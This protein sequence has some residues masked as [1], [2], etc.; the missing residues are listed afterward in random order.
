MRSTPTERTVVC[1]VR[2]PL[3][4]EPIDSQVETLQACEAEGMIDTAILRSWPDEV[5]LGDPAP[6]HETIEVF[7]RFDRWANH[8]GVSIRP[9]F[10]VR[11]MTS[12]VT[13]DTKEVLVTPVICLAVYRDEQLIGVY[14]HSTDDE[15]Y[16]V[17]EALAA[18]RTGELQPSL[19]RS[20]T[21]D[22][23]RATTCP[24]CGDALIDGQGIFACGE[25]GWA[26]T[27]T[28]E[29]DHVPLSHEPPLSSSATGRKSRLSPDR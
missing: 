15:T 5:T 18:L 14:P 26:G 7:E 12:L 22:A 17:T 10:D 23:P 27:L 2:A 19:E 3:L 25:C 13:D 24:E 8:H 20:P 28:A 29:G 4:L 11:T 6:H 1:Y 16:T 9:P 21:H